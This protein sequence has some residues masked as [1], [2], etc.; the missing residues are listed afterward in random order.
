[1]GVAPVGEDE[2]PPVV[3]PGGCNPGWGPAELMAASLRTGSKENNNT[4]DRFVLL[5]SNYMYTILLTEIWMFHC[6]FG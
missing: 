4:R 6:F 5:L 1:M 2:V 3:K